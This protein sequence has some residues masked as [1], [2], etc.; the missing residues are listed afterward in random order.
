MSVRDFPE[1][2]P[3]GRPHEYVSANTYIKGIPGEA[4]RPVI[5]CW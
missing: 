4:L 1:R 5:L 3:S 2:Y